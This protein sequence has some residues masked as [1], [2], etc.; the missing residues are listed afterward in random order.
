MSARVVSTPGMK[1]GWRNSLAL[2]FTAIVRWAVAGLPAQ[3]AN[4]SHARRSTQRPRGM[5]SPLFSA[6]VMNS[7]GP[8]RPRCG[9]SQRTS[10]S[11]PW[12]WF[13]M[14]YCSW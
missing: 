12:G 3:A 5:I 9:C 2:T 10:A 4:C 1:S 13:W 6:S 11:A 7:D 8:T 14:S